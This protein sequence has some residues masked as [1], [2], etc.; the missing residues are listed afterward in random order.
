MA[1]DPD[2]NVSTSLGTYA[3]GNATADHDAFLVAE[4]R[5]AC[6]I[7]MGKTKLWKLNGFKDQTI[8]PGWSALARDTVSR[9]DGKVG[10][11]RTNE[12]LADLS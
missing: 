10:T 5:G 8:S 9:Y 3:F 4:A 11:S 2:L 6:L 12:S 1:T 7:I